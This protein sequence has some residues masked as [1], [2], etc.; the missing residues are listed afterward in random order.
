MPTDHTKSFVHT[1]EAPNSSAP[2]AKHVIE[3]ET[4]EGTFVHLA[5]LARPL[6][7]PESSIKYPETVEV[8]FL[9][10]S[11]E[12][13]EVGWEGPIEIRLD[14]ATAWRGRALMSGSEIKLDDNGDLVEYGKLLIREMEKVDGD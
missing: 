11:F 14:E 1:N 3:I 12:L 8:T 4:E 5:E 6:S 10:Q 2:L 13:P 9:P 7:W